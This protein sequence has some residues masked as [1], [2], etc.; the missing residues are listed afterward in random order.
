MAC[1]QVFGMK[2]DDLGNW[3]KIPTKIWDWAEG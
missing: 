1:S 3:V 2:K